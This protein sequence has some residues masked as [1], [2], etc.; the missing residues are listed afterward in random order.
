[1]AS[2]CSGCKG[3]GYLKARR[4]VDC[5]LKGSNCVCHECECDYGQIQCGVEGR[6]G[7]VEQLHVQ[8]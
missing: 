1:M 4:N 6:R 5:S 2:L 7:R 8:H 3:G